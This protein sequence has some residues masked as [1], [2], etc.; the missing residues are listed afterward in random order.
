M[1]SRRTRTLATTAGAVL[2][3]AACGGTGD[4]PGTASNEPD[5]AELEAV[6]QVA[7]VAVA[8]EL[9]TI[10]PAFAIDSSSSMVINNIYEG[11]YRL[12]ENGQPE[13]AGAADM[14]EVSENGLTHTIALNPEAQWSNG[15]PVTAHD[16]VFA[17]TRAVGLENA[18][19]NQTYLGVIAGA[20]EVIAG[21]AEPESLGV[22]ALDDHTLEVTLESPVPYFTSLLVSTALF[23]L[24]ESYLEEVGDDFGSDDEHAVYNGPF[25][26]QD[27]AGPGIGTDWTY[28]R[29]ED[30]WD[31]E[32]VHLERI[33]VR[34][35]PETNTAI[36]LYR[37]GEVQQVAISGPQVQANANDPGFIAE[38]SATAAFLGYNREVEAFTND[39]LR[40]A[41]SL[42]IDREALAANVLADGSEPATGLIPPGVA[43]HPE[44]GADFTE[45][46]GQSL[47]TDVEEAQQLWAQAQADLG[48]EELQISLETFDADRVRVV[49]EYLQ[50]TIEEN[51]EGITVSITT[52]P[53]ANFLDKMNGGNFDLYLVTWG[54]DFADAS[55]QLSLIRSGAGSN[56]GRYDNAEYDALLDAAAT[57]NA[58]DIDARWQDLVQAHE[59]LIGDQGVTPVYF[60]SSTFL[61]DPSLQG[62]RAHTTGPSMEYKHALRSE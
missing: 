62:V 44:T 18:S 54:A 38:A 55:A 59:I 15:D 26:L 29:N 5:P 24:N 31:A 37:S 61:R 20:N 17:W 23:P 9:N 35:I 11:L 58:T 48:I 27:F 14:P 46:T 13:P 34:V 40:E 16:F 1:R 25:L 56:W 41:I 45:A 21:E 30:Y 39:N 49:A 3:L 57:T 7:T 10:D 51:L 28:V 19:E 33:D 52:N 2:V 43:V 8:Q 22:Q 53:V 50:G 60:Q 42:V 12:D 36:N 4:S 47:S 6:E 32:S